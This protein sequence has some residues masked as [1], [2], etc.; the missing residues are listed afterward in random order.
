ML[1]LAGTRV[2]ACPRQRL[3]LRYV[4]TTAA[5]FELRVLRARHGVTRVRA[6]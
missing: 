2:F 3:R 5:R 4:T 1:A 6:T